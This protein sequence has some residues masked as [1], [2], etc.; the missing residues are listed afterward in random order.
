MKRSLTDAVTSPKGTGG[1]T[2]VTV[3]GFVP[4]GTVQRWGWMGVV[5]RTSGVGVRA[6]RSVVKGPSFPQLRSEPFTH[7]PGSHPRPLT[8]SSLS[9]FSSGDRP[10]YFRSVVNPE[11]FYLEPWYRKIL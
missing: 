9:P 5:G 3:V 8:F 10:L 4:V 6:G 7:R 11:G 2:P 1:G